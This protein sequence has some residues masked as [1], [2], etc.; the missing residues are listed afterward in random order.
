MAGVATLIF[1]SCDKA[2]RCD[3]RAPFRKVQE[4]MQICADKD[5]QIYKVMLAGKDLNPDKSED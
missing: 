1:P 2:I 5:I 4:V 3:K